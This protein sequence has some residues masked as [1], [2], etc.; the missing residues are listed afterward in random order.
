MPVPEV[1]T[2]EKYIDGYGVEKGKC[3]QRN[4][5]FSVFFHDTTPPVFQ[6]IEIRYITNHFHFILYREN[7]Q[8]LFLRSVFKKDTLSCVIVL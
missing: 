1:E 5:N 7:Y 3:Q 6:N 8:F 4:G 2:K